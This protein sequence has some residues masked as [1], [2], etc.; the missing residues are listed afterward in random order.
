MNEFPRVGDTGIFKDLIFIEGYENSSNVYILEG[1]DGISLIDTGNDYTLFFE[2]DEIYGIDNISSIFLTHSHNDHSLG[3]LELL[4]S[5]KNFDDVRIFTHYT[6]KSGLE[7]RVS[8]FEKQNIRVIG[9]TGN[10]EIKLGNYKFK[11]LYAP[12]HTMDSLSLYNSEFKVLFSGDTIASNPIFDSKLGGSLRSYII[13][14]RNYRGL[15]LN[16]IFPGH[17]Y[18]AL[19]GCDEILTHC[20]KKAILALAPDKPVNDVAIAAIKLG[21]I[22]EAEFVLEEYIKNEEDIDTDA[23]KT[24]ASIKA[25]KGDYERVRTLLNDLISSNDFDAIYIAGLSAMKAGKFDDAAE[26]FRKALEI[27]NDKKLK[28]LLGASLFEANRK[29]EALQIEEFRELYLRI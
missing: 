5:Y 1:K 25:D 6:T 7:A 13:T 8:V 10:E 27:K 14:L 24:L 26:L 4:R 20:Y 15:T 21:L 23:L 12:G 17:G 29:E 2:I 18:F 19:G 3:L 16:A 28:I 9:L 22:P 11:V